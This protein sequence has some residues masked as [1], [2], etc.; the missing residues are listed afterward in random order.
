MSWLTNVWN[1]L[2]TPKPPFPP[3]LPP[4]VPP[5]P[6]PT[7]PAPQPQP[8]TPQ[9]KML[10]ELLRLHN[11]ARERNGM[12]PLKL[13]PLLVK[14]AQKHSDWMAANRRMSHMG[15]GFS[16]FSQRIAD[17]GYRMSSGGENVAWNQRD[18]REVTSAWLTSR[19]HRANIMSRN[20]EV[21]FG[22][23]DLYWCAVFAT[24]R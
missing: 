24:P 20:T 21:G 12:P 9:E 13:N 1:W 19:G 10:A 3:P 23:K 17:E 6:G 11:E 14:A 4:Y 16:S 2:F 15:Q 7:P 5:T 18:E 8:P 22:M